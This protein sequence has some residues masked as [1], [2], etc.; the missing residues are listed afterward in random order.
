[1]LSAARSVSF[2]SRTM[3]AVCQRLCLI[4]SPSAINTSAGLEWAD[5]HKH[6]LSEYDSKAPNTNFRPATDQFSNVVAARKIPAAKPPFKKK[7]SSG[8]VNTKREVE[9]FSLAQGAPLRFSFTFLSKMYYA[10][11][12]QFVCSRARAPFVPIKALLLKIFIINNKVSFLT[13]SVGDFVE[14]RID[15]PGR[16]KSAFQPV[17]N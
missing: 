10:L 13:R 1:M 17:L 11:E 5:E 9:R 6:P 12:S 14:N 16:E 4:S 8:I 2:F 3:S 15:V 7:I